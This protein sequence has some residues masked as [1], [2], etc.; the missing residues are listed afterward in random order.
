MTTQLVSRRAVALA[1]PAL[2]FAT[3]AAATGEQLI[4]AEDFREFSA[5]AHGFGRWRTQ[6]GGAGGVR[7]LSSRAQL[8]NGDQQVYVDKGMVGATGIDPLGLDP[9]VVGPDGL[10][11]IASP[12]PAHLL[13]RLWN[14]PFTS[15]L[16]TTR[17]SFSTRYGRF[18]IEAGMPSVVGARASFWLA[19]RD[20]RVGAHISIATATGL[21]P[22]VYHVGIGSQNSVAVDI[23]HSSVPM[24]GPHGAFRSYGI[25]WGPDRISWIL[26]EVE[27]AAVATPSDLQGPMFL[28]IGLS[29]G[30]R[31]SGVPDPI[32]FE[33]RLRVK[34]IAVSAWPT[35]LGFMANGPTSLRLAEKRSRQ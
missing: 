24:S 21:T 15:G 6:L 26:D 30:D 18:R 14:Q 8:Q 1:A 25:D 31:W 16:I 9:F 2:C 20:P 10:E 22:E 4:F 19:S 27:V 23:S 32:G 7:A 12:T 17:F 13:P 11:I 3:S 29:V 5:S 34:S 28:L 35:G 33:A